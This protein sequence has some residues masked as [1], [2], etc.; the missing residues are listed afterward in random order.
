[1]A[2][3]VYQVSLDVEARA[4]LTY[5]REKVQKKQIALLKEIITHYALMSVEER[6]TVS[7]DYINKETAIKRNL[8][9]EYFTNNQM[10]ELE[11]MSLYTKAMESYINE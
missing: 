3:N 10:T 11:R 1:M 2:T 4:V 9:I 8:P 5:L 6:T 7:L